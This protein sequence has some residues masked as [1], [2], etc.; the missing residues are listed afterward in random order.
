MNDKESYE[1]SHG[2]AGCDVIV[3]NLTLTQ[4]PADPDSGSSATL[5]GKLINSTTSACV[6]INFIS[7]GYILNPSG[8]RKKM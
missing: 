6:L 1:N 3:P 2:C 4:P 7:V 8:K 5:E